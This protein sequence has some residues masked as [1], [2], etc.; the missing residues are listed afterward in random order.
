M[1]FDIEVRSAPQEREGI[2]EKH[3]QFLQL[4]GDL[5]A[6]WGA[7]A[8]PSLPA[9]GAAF[10]VGLPASKVFGK[11]VRGDIYYRRRAGLRDSASSDDFLCLSV[12]PRRVDFR[13]LIDTA[14]LAYVR[15]F[16]AY[17]ATILDEQFTLLDYEERRLTGPD[18]RHSMYRVPMAAF[19]SS[20]FS[21]RAFKLNPQAVVDR[22]SGLCVRCE[23]TDGGVFFVLT[24][25]ILDAGEFARLSDQAKALLLRP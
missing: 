23:L 2:S 21:E 3:A 11:G 24:Y 25:D 18:Q 16:G 20:D 17:F 9:T 14:L 13:Y 1:K 10:G 6:P 4:I 12:D 5:A 22:L 19:L 7:E 15:A 8:S